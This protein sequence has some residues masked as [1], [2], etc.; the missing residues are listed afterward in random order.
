M[1]LSAKTQ[2]P[3]VPPR[4]VREFHAASAMALVPRRSLQVTKRLIFKKLS[5]RLAKG[6]DY[7]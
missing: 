7:S 6:E 3:A 4:L 2:R 1:D 5:A